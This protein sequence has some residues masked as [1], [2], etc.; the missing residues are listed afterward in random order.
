MSMYLGED[1]ESA[2]ALTIRFKIWPYKEI[3]DRR[4]A[5]KP[6]TAFGASVNEIVTNLEPSSSV[7]RSD[8]RAE[9]DEQ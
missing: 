5:L 9:T 4:C 8:Q 2:M 3:R 6:A 1:E 7:D